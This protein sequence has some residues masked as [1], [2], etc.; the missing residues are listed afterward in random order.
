MCRAVCIGKWKLD[1]FYF[2]FQ[3]GETRVEC[4]LEIS[5]IFS[6]YLAQHNLDLNFIFPLAINTPFTFDHFD[7]HEIHCE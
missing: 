3:A 2:A 4:D 5:P 6:V 7:L 1:L